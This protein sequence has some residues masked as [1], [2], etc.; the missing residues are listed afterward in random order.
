MNKDYMAMA[1]QGQAKPNQRPITEEDIPTPEMYEEMELPSGDTPEDAKKRLLAIFQELGILKRLDPAG[2]KEL[3][4]KI[5]EYIELAQ[6]GD[7]Q[8]LETHPI[9][10]LLA[11][12]NTEIMQQQQQPAPP[13]G[14]V[15]NGR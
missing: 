12:A 14:G 5:D 11:R 1:Q 8:A 15:M 7:M 9:G 3:N 13:P 4:E 2:L 6:K 10:Q